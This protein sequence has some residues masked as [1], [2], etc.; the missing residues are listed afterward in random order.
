MALADQLIE[1]LPEGSILRSLTRS[2]LDGFLDFAVVKRLGRNE[3]LI[4]AGDPGD[5]MMIVLTG[6]LKVCVDASSGREVVL[7][8]LGPGGIIG[9]IAVFDGKPRTANVIAIENAELVVLQRRVVLPFLEKHPAASLRVIEMLCDTAAA[10]QCDCPGFDGDIE[11]SASRARDSAFA[12]GARGRRRQR[13]LHRIP[14]EPDGTRQL[15]QYFPGKRQ[16]SAAGMGRRGHCESRPRQYFHQR[17][18]GP[19]AD[20]DRYRLARHGLRRHLPAPPSGDPR[21]TPDRRLKEVQGGEAAKI[22]CD[23]PLANHAPAVTR[24]PVCSRPMRC[25]VRPRPDRRLRHRPAYC[26]LCHRPIR[27]PVLR[28]ARAARWPCALRYRF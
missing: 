7:D 14:Y 23:F 28:D 4:E 21:R 26:R 13:N 16:S 15:R 8:Y 1:K 12:G 3:T 17:P 25:R 27:A 9:E 6:T 10:N 22:R 11:S 20:R 18:H 2:E 19:A 24:A 5:S